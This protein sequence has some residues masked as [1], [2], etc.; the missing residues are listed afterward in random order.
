MTMFA[1]QL[2]K[3]RTAKNLS[4]EDLAEQLYIS[5]QSISKWENGDATPDMENLT[6]LAQIF[7]VSLDELVLG[8]RPEVR[9]ER[10]V[11]TAESKSPM[12]AWEFFASYWWL[13][14]PVGA[15]LY[16]LFSAAMKV[17]QMHG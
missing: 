7:Q 8:Q 9:V 12:N 1:H 5:R 16:G 4:Q 13:V 6:K 11:E 2:K 15:F 17:L 3:F 10:V 14:F